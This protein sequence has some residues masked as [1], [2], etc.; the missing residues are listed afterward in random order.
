MN[1]LTKGFNHLDHVPIFLSKL[2]TDEHFSS[3]KLKFEFW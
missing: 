2:Q 3:L 1:S